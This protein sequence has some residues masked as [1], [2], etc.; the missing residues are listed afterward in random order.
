MYS[1]LTLFEHA[2]ARPVTGREFV[3]T[4]KERIQTAKTVDALRAAQALLLPLEFG[5]SLEQTATIIGLSKS[6]TGKLRTRFQ[7]IE[8]GVEQVKTK[9]GLRNHARMS[10]DEEVNFLTP[11]IIEAQNTGALHIPQLKAELERRVGRSVS[12]S[13]VYQLLRRHGW[14]K[15][16]QH[17]RT[18]IEVMQ[19]WKRMGSK[20]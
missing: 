20:K 13:T 9:K 19:A 8:T 11:F 17:P 15:L 14:S 16:A 7:R 6:R 18:D 5:L 3:K 4:A 2:M 1:T 10:L 12:T